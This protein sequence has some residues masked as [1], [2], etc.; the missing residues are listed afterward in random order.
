MSGATII[1]ITSSP[2]AA[3]RV[4]QAGGLRL[5]IVE[6]LYTLAVLVLWGGMALVPMDVVAVASRMLPGRCA[7]IAAKFVLDLHGLLAKAA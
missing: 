1:G 6:S 4:R 2:R 3:I 5:H 7:A